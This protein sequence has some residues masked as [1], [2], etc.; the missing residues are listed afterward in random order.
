MNDRTDRPTPI[1]RAGVPDCL[2]E[3]AFAWMQRPLHGLTDAERALA[4]DEICLLIAQMRHKE[5]RLVEIEQCRWIDRV[6]LRLCQQ[7][8][9]MSGY[10]GA[11]RLEI[12]RCVVASLLRYH[13]WR[14]QVA[15]MITIATRQ[16]DG[17]EI[18]A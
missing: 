8:G 17:G 4:V 11:V 18:Q 10:E 1:E 3:M 9:S 16:S 7:C 15:P 6:T 12:Q 2:V 5:R 13:Q 14:E